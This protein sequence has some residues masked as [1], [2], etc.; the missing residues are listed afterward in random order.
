[1]WLY[2]SR[3]RRKA[4]VPR[5][6]SDVDLAIEVVPGDTEHGQA[7]SWRGELEELLPYAVHVEIT[8]PGAGEIAVRLAVEREGVRLW[9][10]HPSPDNDA[11]PDTPK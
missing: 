2:G 7:A 11:Q 6:D 4:K 10:A 9:R 3:S 8:S 5:P 1:M